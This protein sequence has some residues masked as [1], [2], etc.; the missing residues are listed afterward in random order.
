[1]NRIR[2]WVRAVFG[3]SRTET[4]AFL[5]LLP[6]IA[7]LLFSEPI[8]RWWHD[9]QPSDFS[10]ENRKLDSLIAQLRWTT[11]QDSLT[12]ILQTPDRVHFY[13]FNPNL[14][15]KKEFIAL[16]LSMHT[17][18]RI[19][20]Y[21]EKGGV[22]RKKEDLLRIFGMDSGWYHH[23]RPW[24]VIPPK[25]EVPLSRIPSERQSIAPVLVDINTADS[26]QLVRVYGIGPAL[27]KRI[28]NFRDKLGG[29]I[30]LE[31]LKE[32]SG[33]DSS[34][35]LLLKQRFI[36]SSNFYPQ[37]IDLNK[38]TLEELAQHP[39]IRRKEAQ[40]IVAFRLQ[41]E[42]FQSIDQLGEIRLLDRS[43]IEKVR[44]YLS[45]E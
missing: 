31:Q 30:S 3:F 18:A 24:I 4:N 12:Q 45:V 40:A 42:T 7:A 16:S 17:A 1:M 39:Y 22:F 38:A 29:F 43:W 36:V 9:G 27:S 23:A 10:E 35:V 6:L 13:P 34:V 37:K 19:I 26:A 8:F 21:R 15:S 41:H 5:I 33:L 2:I 14:L 28:R 25:N 20:R 11:D 44:P 32:V